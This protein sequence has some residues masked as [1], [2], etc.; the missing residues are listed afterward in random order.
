[1]KSKAEDALRSCLSRVPFLTIQAIDRETGNRALVP[2]FLVKVALPDGTQDLL[3]EVKTKGQPRPAK[4]AVNALLRYRDRFPKAYGIFLAPFVSPKAAEICREAGMGYVDLA[5]NCR[6]SFG[7]I[8]IEQEGKPNPFREKRDL[9]SLYSPKA[10]RVLR[11]LLTNPGRPWKTEELATEAIVSLGQVS[12]V[13]KLLDDR[14]WTSSTRNGFLL[15]QPD[16]LLEEWAR[17]Y[18][19]RRNLVRNYYSL[20]SVATI[21]GDLA[22]VCSTENITYALTGFS[23]TARLQP[24]VT[25]Q[26]VTVYI[27]TNLDQ[28]AS[29]L[30]LKEVTS[31]S[32]VSLLVPYD[33]GVFYSSR[34][35]DGVWIVS[36]V[37][38][39]LDVASL[40]ARGQEAAEALLENVIKPLWQ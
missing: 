14:E 8:Y 4:E 12:N 31:G 36:P 9:R 30:T 32:N 23:A 17:N 28:V 25:Y 2:D 16:Q 39:Y 11:V 6:L 3:V 18:R 40:P 24:F 20:K 5:G 15:T 7:Q 29:Q 38:C 1:M 37:Q 26:R 35:V 27:P 13:R 21:E 19:Y 10:E 33:E 22:D 34:E